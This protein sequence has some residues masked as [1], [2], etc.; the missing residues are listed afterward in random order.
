MILGVTGGTGGGKT[1]VL[2]EAQKRG[3]LVLDCDEIYHELLASCPE[4]LA[5]IEQRFPGSVENGVLARKK[6][7]KL[8]FADENALRDLNGIT[9]RYVCAEVKRRLE[10][11]PPFA[12][13]DAIGLL[14]S[15][16]SGLCTATVAVTA[17]ME[18]RIARLMAREGIDREY[19]IARIHAQKPDRYFTE[20]CT[21][22]IYNDYPTL[23]QFEIAVNEF[24]DN[25]LSERL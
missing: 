23:E 2:R 8:V 12:V 9:H 21:Y 3:A 17:P 14:E 18:A 16:L 10:Q 4:M 13:I 24:L 5:E 15:G 20:N 6:L 25:L 1:T 19:A 11:K 22:T 7:G